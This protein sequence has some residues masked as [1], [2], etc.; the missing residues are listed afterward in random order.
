MRETDLLVQDVPEAQVPDLEVI[1]DAAVAMAALSPVRARI[2]AVLS[3]PGSATTVARRLG[4]SRQKVNY[5][6]G[7]LE[8]HGLVRLVEERQRRGLTERIMVASA[9]SYVVSAEALGATAA[10]PV[11]TD[12]LST[13]YLVAVA[14][15]LIREV[16]RLAREAD[17]AGQRLSTLTIETEIRFASPAARASFAED[18]ADAVGAL[19]ARYHAG[20]APEG[21]THRL[22]VAAHPIPTDDPTPG[23]EP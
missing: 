8:E 22:V 12:R 16:G 5:H 4:E 21:R 17:A 6:L 18:L 19:A 13:R 10:D 14:A 1:D 23:E 3:Q 7:A 20:D 11:H 15:R 2:L 9:S